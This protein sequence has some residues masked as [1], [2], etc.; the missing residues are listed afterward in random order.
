MRRNLAVFVAVAICIIIAYML[1]LVPD[2][3]AFTYVAGPYFGESQILM[4]TR[5]LNLG[6]LQM[7]VQFL[8]LSMS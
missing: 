7:G 3:K 5:S 2:Y 6:K 8:R 1:F 4:T